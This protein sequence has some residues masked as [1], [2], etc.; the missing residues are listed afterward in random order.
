MI[1]TCTVDK[2]S[3]AVLQKLLPHLNRVEANL[4]RDLTSLIKEEV[5][6]LRES[7][8]E[9]LMDYK[10][11]TASDLHRSLQ[12]TQ[13]LGTKMDTLDLKVVSVNASMREELR[14]MES[15][16]EEYKQQTASVD[17]HNTLQSEQLTQLCAKMDTLYSKLVSVNAQCTPVPLLST[18]IPFTS[19]TSLPLS[20]TSLPPS[21]TSLPPSP[22]SLPPSP[23][24]LPLS[25]LFLVE[26]QEVGDVW[27]T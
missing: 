8:S 9:D 16:L 10:N 23:T 25:P 7:V 21:P 4:R 6:S 24:S 2:I 18:P 13:Q 27:S 14:A 11:Q 20:P 19:S 1:S 22:T 3:D 26:V 12:S 17:L 15:Q 5:T